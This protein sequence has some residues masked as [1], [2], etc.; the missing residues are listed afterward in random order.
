MAG[1]SFDNSALLLFDFG[2]QQWRTLA[3]ANL[4]GYLAWSADSRYVYFDTLFEQNPAYHRV[5]VADAKIET[6]ADL[7]QIRTFPSQFGP[8]SWTGLGPGD[9]PLFVRDTSA[10]EIYALDLQIP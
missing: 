1:L 5:R 6:V 4:M 9:V 7:K 3:H 8:G 2:T 10:Q